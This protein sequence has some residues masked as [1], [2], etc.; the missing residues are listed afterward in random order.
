MIDGK[1][2]FDELRQILT[3]SISGKVK[4]TVIAA[5]Y[6]SLLLCLFVGWFGGLF[7]C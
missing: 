2:V 6:V 5:Q 3:V 4:P 7:V 1:L